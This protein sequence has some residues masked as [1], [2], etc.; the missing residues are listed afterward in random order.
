MSVM[1]QK[2]VE[3]FGMVSPLWTLF[4]R[5]QLKGAD[6]MPARGRRPD[7]WRYQ[8]PSAFAVTLRG[9]K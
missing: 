5:G 1:T 3:Q 4:F 6:E 2:A 8:T 9:C 7:G